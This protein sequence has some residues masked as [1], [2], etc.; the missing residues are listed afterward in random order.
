MNGADFISIG[1]THRNAHS[2]M[3]ALFVC[4]FVQFLLC[5]HSSSLTAKLQKIICTGLIIS[6]S[7]SV[8]FID[9]DTANFT[10]ALLWLKFLILS[11]YQ[12]LKRRH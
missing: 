6:C 8:Y 10:Y 4:L 3:P 11:R 7:L 1:T 5:I 12:H 2:E 9:V